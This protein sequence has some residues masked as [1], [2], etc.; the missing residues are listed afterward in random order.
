MYMA[1]ACSLSHDADGAIND[2]TSIS[3]VEMIVYRGI[4]WPVLVPV[5]PSVS[6]GIYDATGVTCC[7]SLWFQMT[8]SHVP[9]HLDWL[10]LRNSMAPFIMLLTLCATNGNSIG[11]HK[12][13]KKSCCTSFMCL[14]VRIQW[15][16]WWNCQHHMIPMPVASQ[17]ERQSHFISL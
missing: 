12:M 9:P 2:T 1:I 7:W 4:I 11:I 3:H 10:D 5:L 15:C 16:H 17:D 13:R 14:D 6:C 8:K